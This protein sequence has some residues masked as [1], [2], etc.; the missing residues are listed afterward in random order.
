[1]KPTDSNKGMLVFLKVAFVT[2]PLS[3]HKGVHTA[4]RPSMKCLTTTI[5]GRSRVASLLHK[6]CLA[7]NVRELLQSTRCFLLDLLANKGD[8]GPDRGSIWT[9]VFLTFTQT[10]FT[11][12]P[13]DLVLI[14]IF[15][16]VLCCSKVLMVFILPDYIA[17]RIS[18]TLRSNQ[19]KHFLFQN[20]ERLIRGICHQLK[21]HVT[22]KQKPGSCITW[23][24]MCLWYW[25]KHWMSLGK[26][27]KKWSH[28]LL[29]PV[30]N[31]HCSRWGTKR[32]R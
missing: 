28:D 26:K 32:N 15:V 2:D 18:V 30:I 23:I 14:W 12:H 31:L 22:D 19:T 13:L 20:Y 5:R 3:L 27:C 24:S 8:R 21:G 25:F 4:A 11:D 7:E 29:N 1:M 10:H 9:L 6:R 16:H 17:G